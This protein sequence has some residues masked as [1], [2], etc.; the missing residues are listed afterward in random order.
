MAFW[1]KKSDEEDD[2]NK[3]RII[4][5][6]KEKIERL[7]Q[8]KLEAYEYNIQQDT[9]HQEDK[10]R[11]HKEYIDHINASHDPEKRKNGNHE[12]VNEKWLNQ[13]IKDQR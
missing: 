4:E 10:I 9:Y 5:E 8:E 13:Q 12:E 6:Q 3:D 7:E 2:D 1:K 11:I